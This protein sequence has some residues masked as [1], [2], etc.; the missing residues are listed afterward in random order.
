LAGA[1]VVGVVA[2]FMVAAA[3]E[4]VALAVPAGLVEAGDLAVVE[5]S[6]ALE[7]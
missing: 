3:W 7:D 1:S 5:D 6:E 2:A 4:A